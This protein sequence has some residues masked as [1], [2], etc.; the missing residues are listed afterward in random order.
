ME[1]VDLWERG[2]GHLLSDLQ[3]SGT[4]FQGSPETRGT[5]T[6]WQA[7]SSDHEFI[8]LQDISIENTR[9][10]G[11][12]SLSKSPF[13]TTLFPSNIKCLY[14]QASILLSVP[15]FCTQ[16]SSAV[17]YL[18]L[19]LIVCPQR[20]HL[21]TKASLMAW[22]SFLFIFLSQCT[23]FQTNSLLSVQHMNSLWTLG[24]S[25]LLN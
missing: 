22:I 4:I 19:S 17:C 2:A 5:G 15:Q 14:R 1:Q 23:N 3:P 16:L 11:F 25:F 18:E 9:T 6:I 12:L 21:S 7:L 10:S 8:L 20:L 24:F 13:V